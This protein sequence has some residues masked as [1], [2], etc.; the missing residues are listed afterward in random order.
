[1][2]SGPG[3]CCAECEPGRHWRA[4]GGNRRIQ[5]PTKTRRITIRRSPSLA[6][7]PHWRAA[8]TGEPPVVT[9]GFYRQRLGG[10]PSAARRHWRAAVIG[11]PPSLASRRHWRAA[12]IGEP[13]V[14]TGGFYD[15]QRLGG[16]PSAAR[17]V[18]RSPGPPLAFIYERC[19][20]KKYRFIS[21]FREMSVRR[22]AVSASPSS[23][24]ASMP[25]RTLLPT[26][27]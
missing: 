14:V 23:S 13:P 7:R 16:L 10:L 8:F 17:P 22:S 20:S 6:S 15:R 3:D 18:R 25:A 4:A 1:M 19:A 9:G 26:E 27:A 11:E 21:R 12:V 2:G 5:C 24:A